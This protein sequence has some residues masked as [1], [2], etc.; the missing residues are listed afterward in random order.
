MF[1]QLL[2]KTLIDRK[3]HEKTKDFIGRETC[4]FW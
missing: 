1:Y 2:I 3:G 4:A